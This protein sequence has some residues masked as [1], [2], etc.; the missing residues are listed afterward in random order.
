ML[1]AV[2]QRPSIYTHAKAEQELSQNSATILSQPSKINDTPAYNTGLYINIVILLSMIYLV[3]SL[4]TTSF[5][6]LL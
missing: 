3:I 2:R 4:N 6:M 5:I 1:V